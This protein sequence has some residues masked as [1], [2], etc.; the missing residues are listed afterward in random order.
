V[1]IKYPVT[2]RDSWL[3]RRA[4]DLTAS[5][6]AAAAGLDPYKSPL[7]VYAEK[8]GA[9]LPVGDN[10]LMRRG[11]WL[12]PA[13]LQAIRDTRPDWE[14]R[15]VGMY[16]RDTELHLGAT[17]DAV[18]ITD[19]PGVTNIQ[20]KVVGPRSYLANWSD[21]PPIGYLLQTICEGMLMEADQSILAALV[22]DTY[23]AELFLHDVDRHPG[24]EARIKEIAREFW[25][26]VREG[27]R[28]APKMPG[29]GDVIEAIY[30][31]A[32]QEP[33]LDLSGDNMLRQLLDERA[34]A[35]LDRDEAQE[36]I[37]EID[38]EVKGKMGEYAQATLPGWKLSW[39]TLNRREYTVPAKSYRRLT[40]TSLEETT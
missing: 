1:I 27:K 13:V 33:V 3:L 26:N 39:P 4:E 32:K 30:P 20:C 2:D 36:R 12:E 23:S 40:I 25:L 19:K 29:D 38:S 16:Y 10:P 15:P 18:A 37:D 7:T 21:G 9:I 24:A 8:T 31:V 34:L 22:V 28:P 11:R 5:D 6:I 17:P 14:V 35:K